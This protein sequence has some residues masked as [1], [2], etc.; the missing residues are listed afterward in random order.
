MSNEEKKYSLKFNLKVEE[1]SFGAKDLETTWHGADAIYVIAGSKDAR[2]PSLWNVDGRIGATEGTPEPPIGF[3]WGTFT[4]MAQRL[5]ET[6]NSDL[7]PWKRLAAQAFIALA[8]DHE[9]QHCSTEGFRLLQ[10]MAKKVQ[11]AFEEAT[12][13]KDAAGEKPH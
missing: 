6:E 3:I 7:A 1:G 5:A 2:D 13:T 4:L 12:T 8:G 10:K 9:C 11:A